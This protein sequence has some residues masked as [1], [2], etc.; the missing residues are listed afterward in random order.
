VPSDYLAWLL[1]NA[2]LSSGLRLAVADEL[3]GRGRSVPPQE[4]PP[5]LPRCRE[6]GPA[7]VIHHS[8]MEDSRGEQRIQR[9]CACGRALG[10]APHLPEFVALA[11]A[12]A[13]PTAV[14]DVL[15]EC[16]EKGIELRSDGKSVHVSRGW[17]RLTVPLRQKLAQCRHGLAMMLGEQTVRAE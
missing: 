4:P 16:E 7:T 9:L 13:S 8:W 1:A 15:T 6:C 14:L 10:F 2:K 3:R 12:A 11:D 17:D 5:P